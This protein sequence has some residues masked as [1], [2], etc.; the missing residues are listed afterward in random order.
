MN[1][2]PTP[3][4]GTVYDGETISYTVDGF[5]VTATI[6][7]DDDATPPWEREDGHGPVSGWRDA[8]SKSPGELVLNTDRGRARFYDYAAACQTARADGWGPPMY[9][10]DVERGKGGLV[11][12]NSQWFIGRDLHT[13][14]S[15]WADDINA[16]YRQNR[17]A[18][19]AS[20][21]SARAY[22]AAA[23]RADFDRLE[24]W[25]R[26][27]WQ[28]VG[29]AVTVSRAGVDLTG[30]YDH[31]CWGIESDCADYLTEVAGEHV[32]DALEA[33]RA[34][35]AELADDAPDGEGE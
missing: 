2:F 26:D 4:T 24:S 8:S 34:K 3:F 15:D 28:Y 29:V 17:E 35:I 25:C 19:R 1:A 6:H 32:D 22:H 9:R 27:G 11:R 16:A 18:M 20:Y 31:A 5:T 13:A 7:S 33:A 12:V 23:A 10:E 21:P 30:P 14:E